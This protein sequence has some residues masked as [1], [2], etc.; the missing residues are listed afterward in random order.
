MHAHEIAP[1]EV[2][3][4]AAVCVTAIPVR[5][6]AWKHAYA[7][8]FDATDKSIVISGDTTSANPSS[9]PPTA[10]TSWCTYSQRGGEARTPE[11]R[12][13]HA[14]YHTSAIDLSKLAAKVQ[15]KKL[16]L[17]HELPMG[18]PESEVLSEIR[19]TFTGEIIYRK[20]LDTI[21]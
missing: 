2:Y 12:R 9:T 11:W 8:R 16:V 21:R 6:G 18:Q 3:R 14:A 13:Y 5:H 17:Y 19:Q 10:V 15:P 7:Y 1:G 20:D 4:D